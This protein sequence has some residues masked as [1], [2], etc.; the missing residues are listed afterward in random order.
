MRLVHHDEP[1]APGGGE[2]LGVPRKELRRGERDVEGAV[3]QTREPLAALLGRALSREDDHADAE[4]VERFAQVERLVGDERAQRIDEQ[5]GLVARERA[6]GG[7]HLE[8]ERLAAPRR[9]DAE[10]RPSG[11]QMVEHFLLGIVQRAVADDGA[12]DFPLERFGVG[13]GPTLPLRAVRG[14][15]GL[16][17]LHVLGTMRRVGHKLGVAR[18]V[19]VGHEREVLRIEAR[20][21]RAARARGRKRLQHGLHRA[22][23]APL[24]DL[25]LERGVHHAVGAHERL[26]VRAVEHDARHRGAAVG[27]RAREVVLLR[28]HRTAVRQRHVARQVD[29]HGMLLPEGGELIELGH[30]VQ[31]ELVEPHARVDVHER[32]E[33][34]L[35]QVV[36][37][38]GEAAL[39]LRQ[40]L[41]GQ[42]HSHGRSVAPEPR[43]QI[44]RA[45][46]RL[47][48]VHLAHAA[49]RPAR[50]VAV[51][52]EQQ[53][54]HAVGVHQAARHDALHALVPALSRHHE[55]ALAVVDLC[56]LGLR[57]LRKLSLDGAALVV[58]GLQ[59][60]CQTL[61]L[62]QIVG[63][64]QIERQLG[65]PHA[66]GGV[67]ARNDRKAEV[68]GADGLVGRAARGKKRGDA[69]TRGGVHARDAVGDERT[70][71]AAHGHEVGH[72]AKR[73]EV[74]VVA[75]QVRL[76]QAA[77][78]HLHELE[79]HAHAGQD[80]AFAG[81]IA[82]RIGHGH[83]L[84]HEVGW[85]VV[86]GDGQAQT[87]LHDGRRLVLAGDAAV[88]RDDEVRTERARA[89]EGGLGERVALLEAQGDERRC[90]GAK[91]AQAAGEHGGGRDAVEVEVAEH[92]DVVA[93]LHG[94]LQRV[95][96][97]GKAGDGIGVEPVAVE[98]G[99]EEAARRGI[100]D[101][102]AGDEG[103]C[104]EARKAERAL[105]THH[106]LLIGRL[107]VEPGRH[108]LRYLTCEKFE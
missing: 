77:A 75:P 71:L 1:H 61:G 58:H 34:P 31:G 100:V 5:A 82:L 42:R 66:A 72:G 37:E 12:H 38:G 26:D 104:D 15:G 14:A 10:H 78:Q 62:G 35:R 83:A 39:E 32:M 98:R 23:A 4:A 86:V 19:E 41:R 107:D 103:G 89:H 28:A 40:V 17:G 53:A 57:D 105:E 7:V 64:E 46:H 44:G 25:H 11:A 68:R 33:R 6:H 47:E 20:L 49:A 13:G 91:G 30:A 63:H 29:G 18:G 9:H 27:E 70:V 3:G 90:R 99:R 94:G 80:G 81:G 8:R 67:E 87:R 76:A 22:A 79:R 60:G 56:G 48:Q 69:R 24:V 59:L 52:G 2:L 54:G 51:D 74:G 101:D 108:G 85:L 65:V 45:L 55:R 88:H 73:S 92:E 102:A 16:V 96:H 84:G 21:E 106:G 97:L 93:A 50:L 43:E 36:Q 95:G